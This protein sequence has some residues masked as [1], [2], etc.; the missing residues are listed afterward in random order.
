MTDTTS[1]SPTVAYGELDRSAETAAALARERAATT[2]HERRLPDELVS[3]LQA[4][5]LLRAG[6]PA[7]LGAAQAPARVTLRCAE[8]VARG[9][10]SAGWCVSIAATSSLLSGWLGEE[11]RAEVF[12][13]AGSVAAGVWAP[14]GKA[15]RV[16]G[17]YHVSGQWAFCS[18]IMHSDY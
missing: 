16:E 6:A 13:D 10:A 9:D 4:S 12:G 17:G 5:G 18:G 7:A 2:E 11:G 8:T 3:S 15:H 1:P 14:R